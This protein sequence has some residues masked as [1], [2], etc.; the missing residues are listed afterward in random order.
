M[1]VPYLDLQAQYRTLSSEIDAEIK[2]V[3]ESGAF[4]LGPELEALE[5]EFAAFCGSPHAVGVNSG[6]SALHLALLAAGV[7]PGD[8]VLTVPMTFVATVAAIEYARAVPRFVDIH[9][10][11]KTIDPDKISVAI[12]PK[13]KAIIPVHLHGQPC[14]MAPLLALAEQH[15][16]TVIEDAAQAHAAA[17][18]G[19]TAGTF[20]RFGC[21]SFYPGKNLG[22]YGEGG[23]VLCAGQEDAEQIKLLRNWGS[24]RRYHH[25][26]RGFNYRLDAIQSAILRVKLRRL[27]G[28]TQRRREIAALYSRKLKDAP[29]TLPVEL[30]GS[31]H[32][33]HVYAVGV[34]DRDQ[35]ARQLSERG[36]Q[37]N[38][39]YPVPVHLQE[40]YRDLG[41]RA[42]DFPESEKMAAETLS[43]PIYPE[44]TNDQVEF[45]CA[46]LKEIVGKLG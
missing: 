12:T 43:L 3:L 36:I 30:P 28:W 6:T 2:R 26:Q 25:E 1:K 16:L 13:T 41:Y 7:Q 45:V 44:M 32:V 11:Y 20:G 24:N 35:V 18:R 39:H 42:G 40:G 37:T 10:V 29:L 19:K 8:E 17:Y 22:A 34:K 23:M 15:G 27:T 46:Q 9:P 31:Q 4:I 5:H 21:F 14:D 38:A 33:H